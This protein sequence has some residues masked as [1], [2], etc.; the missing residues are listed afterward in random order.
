[1]K[2]NTKVI[3][4][5]LGMHYCVGKEIAKMEVFLIFTRLMQQFEILPQS[6]PLPTLYDSNSGLTNNPKDYKVILKPRPQENN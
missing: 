6:E 4:L 1:M 3:S 5:G 2:E